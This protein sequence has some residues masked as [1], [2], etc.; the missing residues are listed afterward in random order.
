MDIK[1]SNSTIYSKV[2]FV[3]VNEYAA[4]VFL[5]VRVCVVYTFCVC[6]ME[7]GPALFCFVLFFL[8]CEMGNFLPVPSPNLA[9]HSE[10]CSC[11]PCLNANKKQPPGE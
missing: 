5:C 9:A 2:H 8:C 1:L 11:S 4:Q 7:G 3:L 10:W 6:P